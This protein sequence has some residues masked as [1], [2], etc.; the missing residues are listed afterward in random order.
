MVELKFGPKTVDLPYTIRIS[1]VSEEMFDELVDEDT[2]AEFIDGV[3]IVHSPA[4]PR[5]D[6]VSAFL[7][8]L[9]RCY[10]RRKRL[11]TVLGPDSLVRLV[12]GRRFAPDLYFLKQARIPRP[13]PRKQFEGVPDL[14]GEILSP[15]NRDED[16]HLKRPAY[17][18]A[19]VPEIWLVDLDHEEVMVDLKRKKAYTT[20]RV[21]KV[22]V[23]S[24]VLPGFW[25]DTDWLWADP[26]PDELTCLQELL[27]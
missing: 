4:S 21:R 8:T 27:G 24:Q 2:R 19:G 6:D 14:V 12:T 20:K 18:Q 16:L 15:S 1:D 3:M 10:A 13:L 11:G 17:R 22:R 23:V 5:H 9:M 25:I 26:L 7:R